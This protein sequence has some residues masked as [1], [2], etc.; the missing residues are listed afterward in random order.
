LP[1]GRRHHAFYDEKVVT[2]PDSHQV[3]DD[4]RNIADRTFTREELGITATVH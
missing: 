3:N 4:K 1:G 2:L